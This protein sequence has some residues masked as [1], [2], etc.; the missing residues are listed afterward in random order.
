MHETL[1]HFHKP[2]TEEE[3][4]A[5]LLNYLVRYNVMP[6]R[7]EPYSRRENWQKHLPSSGIRAMCSWYKHAR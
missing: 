6:H 4:N 7:S 3:A 2:Q 5:W 1:Y